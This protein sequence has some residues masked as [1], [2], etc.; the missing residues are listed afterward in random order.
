MQYARKSFWAH[1][2]NSYVTWVMWKLISVRLQTV[3]LSAQGRCTIC[4]EYSTRMEI[5]FVTPNGPPRWRGSN[6]SSFGLLEDSA[7]LDTRL[8][9]GLRQTRNRLRNHFG[10]TRWNSLVTWAKWKLASVRLEL[11]LISKEH[12]CTLWGTYCSSKIIMGAPSGTPR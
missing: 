11:V 3:L 4:T 6:G 7:N 12:R 2:V 9:H 8:M 5:F 10:C 1:P